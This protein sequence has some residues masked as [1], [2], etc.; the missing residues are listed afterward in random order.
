MVRSK[1]KPHLWEKNWAGRQETG[2]CFSGGRKTE[3]KYWDRGF[4]GV[5]PQT[6]YVS[7]V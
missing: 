7:I 2:D 6:Y 4:V 3:L 1:T 5:Q